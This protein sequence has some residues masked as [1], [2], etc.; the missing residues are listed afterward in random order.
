[1]SL[2]LTSVFVLRQRYFKHLVCS[3]GSLGQRENLTRFG[4]QAVDRPGSGFYLY[5]VEPTASLKVFWHG[6]TC[7]SR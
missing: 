6:L 2:V 1:M 5:P 7:S 4:D 3:R